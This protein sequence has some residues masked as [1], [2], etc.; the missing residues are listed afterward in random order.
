[1]PKFEIVSREDAVKRTTHTGKRGEIIA[2]YLFFIDQL[3]DGKAGKLKPS[4]NETIQAI[5]RRLGAAAKIA[6]KNL[7]IKRVGD[8]VYFW[9]DPNNQRTSKRR[10][11]P[12]KTERSSLNG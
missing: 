4:E 8:E 10:G 2:L 3:K 7:T 11:R 12:R 1:M 6:E 5:R 9:I